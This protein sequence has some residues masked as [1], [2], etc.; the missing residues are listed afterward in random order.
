MPV[1]VTPV[2]TR[3]CTPT[4][5]PPSRTLRDACRW[6][7]AARR[8]GLREQ[9]ALAFFGAWLYLV[10]LFLRKRVGVTHAD[11]A[12]YRWRDE[13]AAGTP[14][15]EAALETLSRDDAGWLLGC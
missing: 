11:L 6:R 4:T 13:Y 15:R 1:T 7:S 14:P 12:D 3:A 9:A 10:D 2:A 5:R 8:T